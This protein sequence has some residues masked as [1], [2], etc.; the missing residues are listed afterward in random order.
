MGTRAT[1]E[2]RLAGGLIKTPPINVTSPAPTPVAPALAAAL[3]LSAV[4]AAVHAFAVAHHWHEWP[5]AAVFLA[6]VAFAQT[7]TTYVLACNPTTRM[8]RAIA[9]GNVAVAALWIVSRATE[10]VGLDGVIATAAEIALAAI[11]LSG[12]VRAH[13][14]PRRASHRSGARIAGQSAR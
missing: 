6:V 10:P 8:R 13:A 9:F 2:A 11:L 14:R 3:T 5:A 4:A 1:W 12:N 7:A